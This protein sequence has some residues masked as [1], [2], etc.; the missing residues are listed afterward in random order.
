MT[1]FGYSSNYTNRPDWKTWTSRSEQK[2]CAWLLQAGGLGSPSPQFL[3]EQLTLSQPGAD[4]AHPGP[5]QEGGWGGFSPPPPVF[6]RTVN[7]I[8]TRGSR[9]CPPQYYEPPPDFQTLRRP[10][11]HSTT[12][13]SPQIVRPCNGPAVCWENFVQIQ[14]RRPRIFDL[15]EHCSSVLERFTKFVFFFYFL[16]YLHNKNELVFWNW[17]KQVCW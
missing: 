2:H 4:Y 16:A 12:C 6:G 15:S 5:S 9:L 14:G 3:P 17:M 7:P 1:D 13:P 8:S 11:H 10:C